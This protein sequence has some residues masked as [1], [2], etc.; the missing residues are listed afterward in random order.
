MD[1]QVIVNEADD[2][3]DGQITIFFVTDRMRYLKRN[4]SWTRQ[5]CDHEYCPI[6]SYSVIMEVLPNHDFD[7]DPMLW[8]KAHHECG[9]F[10]FVDRND[11]PEK[12]LDELNLIFKN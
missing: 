8:A 3:L 4:F 9:E 11:V 6:A 7:V 2:I 1:R 12:I 5:I 10:V